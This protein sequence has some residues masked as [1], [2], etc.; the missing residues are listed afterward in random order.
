[1]EITIESG[2]FFKY[3]NYF[4]VVQF[5]KK[6]ERTRVSKMTKNPLFEGNKFYFSF[7]EYKLFISQTIT[8]TAFIINEEN[9]T[10]NNKLLGKNI[11]ELSS[12]GDFTEDLNTPIMRKIELY[13]NEDKKYTVGKITVQFRL[14]FDE[15]ENEKEEKEK[16]EKEENEK[17]EIEQEEI[18]KEEIEQEEIE[19][20]EIEQEENEQEIGQ[21]DE[22]N[23]KD[24]LL[25]KLNFLKKH[26]LDFL[27]KKLNINITGKEKNLDLQN[28]KIGNF[29]LML[30]VEVV[31]QDLESINLSHNNISDVRPLT[32]LKHLKRI[33]LSYNNLKDF[34]FNSTK[35]KKNL[36]LEKN[37]SINLDNNGL[38]EKEINEI[39]DII[40]ND[41][42]TS[43]N[44]DDAKDDILNKLINKL[45]QLEQ[46]ILSY[47]NNKLNVELTGKELKIDLNNKNIEN[48][49]LYLL[50]SV[51]F[52]NLEEI[53]LSNNKISNIE[54][55]KNF[56]N[57]KKIDLSYNEINKLD[58]L[59]AISE[60][61]IKIEILYFNNNKIEDV[62]ILKQNIFPNII[63]INLDNNNIIK[64]EIEEIKKIIQKKK[65]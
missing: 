15:E 52:N 24:I 14:L 40:K 34:P 51:D 13:Q 21:E 57:L 3:F 20:E 54:P 41:F 16:E 17:E 10:F 64:K 12:L 27:N 65:K 33:D 43:L 7:E 8:F 26:I 39:N 56:K 22:E 1:M 53:N 5:N 2:E 60:N 19:Q 50:S 61:N 9:G 28:K 58:A 31:P 32:Y 25:N 45:N 18:E 48:I 36:P 49:D 30:I 63:E 29:E 44:S 4:I 46:K 6:Q 42:E 23:E 38:I 11:F 37:I 47:F 55:L 35:I 62:E 59:K